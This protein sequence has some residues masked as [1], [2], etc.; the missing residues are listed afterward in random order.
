[1][2]IDDIKVLLESMIDKDFELSSIFT[3]NEIVIGTPTNV[4][5]KEVGGRGI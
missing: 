3:D 1:M 5:E 2:T 4:E